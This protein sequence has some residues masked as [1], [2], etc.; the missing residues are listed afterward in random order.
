MSRLRAASEADSSLTE[1]QIS[2]SEAQDV[3][4]PVLGVLD[5]P[6]APLIQ[7]L[8]AGMIA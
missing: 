3:R 7:T 6:E 5:A 8:E 4:F 2:A 1:G